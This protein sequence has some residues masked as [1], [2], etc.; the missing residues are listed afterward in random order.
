[1]LI[2]ES[3][4]LLIE[5]ANEVLKEVALEFMDMVDAGKPLSRKT[6]EA[7]VNRS[8]PGHGEI[9]EAADRLLDGHTL[10]DLAPIARKQIDTFSR[11]SRNN[12]IYSYLRG[13]RDEVF[14]RHVNLVTGQGPAGSRL[15]ARLRIRPGRIDILTITLKAP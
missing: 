8:M 14:R 6:W 15:S 12:F 11:W 7:A 1:M 2:C 9:V 13:R 5:I 10:S 4:A 3:R